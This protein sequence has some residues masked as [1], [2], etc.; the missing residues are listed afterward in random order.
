MGL[1]ICVCSTELRP[2]DEPVETNSP[3]TGEG[4]RIMERKSEGGGGGGV[5]VTADGRRT[6]NVVVSER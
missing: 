4:R 6:R 5:T 1:Q 3:G 2:T